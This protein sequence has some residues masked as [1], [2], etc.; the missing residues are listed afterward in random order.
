MQSARRAN[1][2]TA[3]HGSEASTSGC[4]PGSPASTE[5]PGPAAQLHLAATARALRR[6]WKTSECTELES[7]VLLAQA[8]VLDSLASS[9]EHTFRLTMSRRWR[10]WISTSL[11]EG[12]ARVYQWV[13]RP[14]RYDTSEVYEPPPERLQRISAEWKAIWAQGHPG[15]SRASTQAPLTPQLTAYHIRKASASFPPHTAVGIDGL[16]PRHLA[17]LPDEALDILAR[18]YS[19]SEA[20][21]QP[22]QMGASI[23]FLP[24]PTGGG[25]THWHTPHA[26]SR[27]G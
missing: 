11:R 15:M 10:D 7:S 24:K 19:F 13:S 1:I 3:S 20:L 12:G 27:L 25:K 14:E 23:V 6:Y 21:G 4:Q 16:R 17:L 2:T 9:L 8:N 5:D 18:L 26:L 22:L